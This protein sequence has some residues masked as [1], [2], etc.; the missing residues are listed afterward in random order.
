MLHAAVDQPAAQQQEDEQ[1]GAQQQRTRSLAAQIGEAGGQPQRGHGHAEQHFVQLLQ[2]R[3]PGMRDQVQRAQGGD[4]EE[5]DGEAGNMQAAPCCAVLT[6]VAQ[7]TEEEQRG[8]QQ[9]DPQ[10]LADQRG[11][12]GG[13]VH[14]AAGGHHLGDFVD[15]RTAEDAERLA[16][17]EQ[18]RHVVEQHRMQEHRQGAEQHHGGDRDRRV[19]G[20]GAQHRAARHHRRRP[21]DGATGADQQGALA[22]QAQPAHADPP[23]DEQCAADHQHVDDQRRRAER[24]DVLEG[25][26]QTV[27]HHAQ[28]QQMLARQVYARSQHGEPRAAQ[29]AD[30]Q[31]E[32]DGQGQ[33]AKAQTLHAGQLDGKACETGKDKA[34]QGAGQQVGDTA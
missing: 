34:E 7:L 24:G 18:L 3:Q 16:A 8:S 4:T 26:T 6:V 1:A 21:A 10:H 5:G 20:A 29:I 13:R 28:A 33:A 15:G 2:G 30:Q 19:F 22:R 9:E 11:I 14:G 17:G 23:G 31:T 32:E 25:Q 27:Q 12:G